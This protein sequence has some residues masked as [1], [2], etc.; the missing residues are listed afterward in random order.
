MNWIAVLEN[1]YQQFPKTSGSLSPFSRIEN[2]LQKRLGVTRAVFALRQ[3]KSLKTIEGKS[4]LNESEQKEILLYWNR[5]LKPWIP[6][7][8]KSSGWMGFWPVVIGRDGVGCFALGRKGHPQA[9]SAEEK[10][11]MELL[12]DRSA[13]YLRERRLWQHLEA[14]NRQSSLGFRSAAMIH[15]IRSP[16][17][18]LSVLVQLLP[19]KR[20]DE[21]FMLSI[22]QLMLREINRLSGITEDFLSFTRPFS[23]STARFDLSEVLLQVV[24]L[25]GPLFEVKKVRLKVKNTPNLFLKGKED[26][27]ESLI[28]NLLQNALESVGPRGQVEI[29]TCLLSHSVYGPG[30]WIELKVKDNGKGFSVENLKRIFDP[31]FSTKSRGTGLGLAI[32]QKVAQNHGGNIEASASKKGTE[33]KVL[34]SAALIR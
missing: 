27:M 17:T 32:C 14:A 18:A 5:T 8:Q 7:E 30:P 10:K 2:I 25:L 6:K 3:E 12:A 20:N 11:L 9:L 29:S 24:R 31:Y 33:F 22:Q 16:L 21:R 26:Q 34:L 4:F 15:E 13:L 23:K 19:E 28:L 1:L